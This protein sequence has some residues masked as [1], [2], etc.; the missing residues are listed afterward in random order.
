M[1]AGL[2]LCGG[3]GVRSSSLARVPR[4]RIVDKE[5]NEISKQH[6]FGFFDAA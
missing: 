1:H 4:L 6:D 3:D 5:L 2:W